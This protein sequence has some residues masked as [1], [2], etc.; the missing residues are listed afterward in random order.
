MLMDTPESSTVLDIGT[1]DN[2]FTAKFEAFFK[3]QSKKDIEMLVE[4]Y[5]EKRSLSI[6]FNAL[7]RFWKNCRY[8]K[9]PSETRRCLAHKC[10]PLRA[11]EKR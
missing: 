5:P 7:E 2:P 11:P 9:Y 1:E 6:D 10:Q 8:G 4:S 3:L